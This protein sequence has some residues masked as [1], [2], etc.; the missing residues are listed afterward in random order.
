MVQPA[1]VK[2]IYQ[3]D[4]S[5]TGLRLVLLLA[6][7]VFSSIGGFLLMPALLNLFG[8]LSLPRLL[9]SAS[10]GLLIG[11]GLTMIL[12]RIL[13][14]TWP[15]GRVLEVDADKVVLKGKAFDDLT[16]DWGS[17]YEVLSWYFPIRRG[18]SYV[19]RGWYMVAVRIK[20]GDTII[21]PYAF[22][23]PRQSNEFLQWPVF[24]RLISEKSARTVDERA[25]VERQGHLRAAEDERW[26]VGV[27]MRPEDFFVFVGDLDART[28]HWPG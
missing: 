26:Y 13:W 24:E 3:L 1:P 11:F 12:E 4:R 25:Q 21:I 22:F 23:H 17:P 5:H 18:R 8:V 15:S 2:K 20:Q 28:P 14:S 19:P 27:E 16:I 10:G 7:V 9:L 6:L